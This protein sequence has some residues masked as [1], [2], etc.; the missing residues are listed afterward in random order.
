MQ[1]QQQSETIN[2]NLVFKNCALF[3]NYTSKINNNQIDNA[4]DLDIMIP[5]YNLLGYSNIYGKTLASLQ[6]CFRN[7][8]DHNGIIYSESFK[9]RSRFASNTDNTGTVNVEIAV[10]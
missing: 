2:K 3:T 10:P 5:M 4:E 9:F 7:E 1:K 6:Q 8:P